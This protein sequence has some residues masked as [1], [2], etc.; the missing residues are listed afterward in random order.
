M[1]KTARRLGRV[2]KVLALILAVLTGAAACQA[3]LEWST[4]DLQTAAAPGQQT[5]SVTFPFRNAGDKPVR[6]LSLDPSCSCVSATPDKGV[7]ASGASGEIRIALAL[8]GYSGRVRRSVAVTTDDAKGRSVELTLTVDIPEVVV[9]TP[10][11]LFW[12]VG[13]QAGEKVVDV[14]VTD[15]KTTTLGEIECANARFLVH[16]LPQQHGTFRLT[17]RPADTRQ[18]D[19]AMVHLNVIVGGQPQTRVIYTA[20]K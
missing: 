10:R 8:G 18:P 20:V 14:V 2:I 1:G 15:P 19:E 9:I 3:G 4:T 5:V 6:I 11:F 16:V 17:V 13:E 7:C 12:R